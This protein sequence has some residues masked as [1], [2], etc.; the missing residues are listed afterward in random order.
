MADDY[1]ALSVSTGTLFDAS[2]GCV[3]LPPQSNCQKTCLGESTLSPSLARLPSCA[4]VIGRWAQNSHV[5]VSG[6][7]AAGEGPPAAPFMKD[8]LQTGSDGI[9]TG[10][11]CCRGSRRVQR[12]LD[13]HAYTLLQWRTCEGC[14]YSRVLFVQERILPS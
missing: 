3:T 11:L 8:S 1:Q 14:A 13:L 5:M 10:D 4:L 9:R 7:P 6:S 12:G 2:G